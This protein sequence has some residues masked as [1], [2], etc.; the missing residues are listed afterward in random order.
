MADRIC[1]MDGGMIVEQG[2]HQEL[3]RQNGRYALL[4]RT[5]AEGYRLTDTEDVLPAG[6]GMPAGESP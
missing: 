4:Y 6:G 3:L 5:Q 1:V 2:T